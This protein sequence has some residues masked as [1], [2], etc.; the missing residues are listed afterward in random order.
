MD[1]FLYN[2]ADRSVY[3]DANVSDVSRQ[4]GELVSIL[5][6]SIHLQDEQVAGTPRRSGGSTKGV[7][8][9]RFVIDIK[10]AQSQQYEPRSYQEAVSDPESGD[11]KAVMNDEL[12]LLREC[13]AREM[14]LLTPG[15]KTIG[16]RWKKKQVEQGKLVR[17]K[18]RLVAQGF[19]QRYG[20]D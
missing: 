15:S 20:L 19:T 17:H 7:P 9:E 16:G 4:D 13:K 10:L 18:A 11:W 1:L 8:L 3:E 6:E 14:T 12:K 5:E 2:P